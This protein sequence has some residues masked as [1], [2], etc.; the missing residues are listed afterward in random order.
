M[1]GTIV[2]DY[3]LG[4]PVELLSSTRE[5]QEGQG[6]LKSAM[7]VSKTFCGKFN[8]KYD[9]LLCPGVQKKI[10]GRSFNLQDPSDWNA[11]LAAGAHTDSTKCM[12]V[13]G[14]AAQWVLEILIAKKVISIDA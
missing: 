11:F 7:A 1:G 10:Y 14:N 2:L 6:A 4:R 13:V 12:S 5:N 9:S 8:D 3:F